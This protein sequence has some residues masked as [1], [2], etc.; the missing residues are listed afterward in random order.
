MASRGNQGV[1]FGNPAPRSRIRLKFHE[2][3]LLQQALVHRS[4]LNEQ[5]GNPSDSYERLEYL[6]DAVIELAVS[7]CLFES[8]PTHSEGDLTKA[9]ANLVC[10]ES[11]ANI[12]RRLN[13]G[14][15]LQLGRGEDSTGGAAT[16]NHLGRH[17]RSHSSRSIPGSGIPNGPQ[18]RPAYN[19]PRT[20][21]VL[22]PR[23]DP[24][25]SEVPP[26]RTNPV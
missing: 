19:G 12:V 24:G 20:G 23:V 8:L 26:P 16:R 6:G 4:Y 25:Q 13:L 15:H 11:L 18:P 7:A 5:G 1:V 14:D 9:R 21:Q 10:G 3:G 2:P 17:P 22:L